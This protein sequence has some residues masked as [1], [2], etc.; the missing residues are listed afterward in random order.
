MVIFYSYVSLQECI[1]CWF[2]KDHSA[3]LTDSN[4]F[5]WPCPWLVRGRTALHFASTK[6]TARALLRALAD[7]AGMQ[8]DTR[9]HNWPQLYKYIYIYIDHNVD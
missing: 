7:D 6:Q 1:C 5:W 4:R 8:A 3:T 2:V 9:S